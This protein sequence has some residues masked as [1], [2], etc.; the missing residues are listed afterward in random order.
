MMNKILIAAVASLCGAEALS[1]I[2]SSFA[3]AD[4]GAPAAAPAPQLPRRAVSFRD[5][6][7]PL[8]VPG[9]ERPIASFEPTEA[10]PAPVP[11]D[12]A[13]RARTADG[14]ADGGTYYY[15]S[16]GTKVTHPNHR[17]YMRG[18]GHIN[19]PWGEEPRLISEDEYRR[20]LTEHPI[21]LAPETATAEADGPQRRRSIHQMSPQ[22]QQQL[23]RERDDAMARDREDFDEHGQPRSWA[24]RQLYHLRHRRPNGW[25]NRLDPRKCRCL[26][27]GAD[28]DG[29]TRLLGPLPNLEEGEYD[30]LLPEEDRWEDIP[31]DAS[32]SAPSAGRSQRSASTMSFAP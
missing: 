6:Q 1:S 18:C 9:P 28:D 3:E 17:M 4:A 19:L 23:Q 10:A 7:L 30:G 2:A 16:D 11:I 15:Y 8:D 22:E 20:L 31:R 24:G 26:G 21:P 25:R 27:G 13:T 32:F 12:A 5:K 14:A 29:R